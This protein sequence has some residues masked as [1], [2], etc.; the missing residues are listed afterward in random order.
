MLVPFPN[1]PKETIS[2]SAQPLVSSRIILTRYQCISDG[3][4]LN[5]IKL[6]SSQMYISSIFIS[7]LPIMKREHHQTSTAKCNILLFDRTFPIIHAQ[8]SLRSKH[9]LVLTSSSFFDAAWCIWRCSAYAR[10]G[11]ATEEQV[12]RACKILLLFRTCIH[13]IHLLW[14]FN[15]N[16]VYLIFLCFD[17]A[18]AK[19]IGKRGSAKSVLRW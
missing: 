8:K 1:E 3:C 4:F 5:H 6:F 2:L 19:T 18:D 9:V 16:P 12:L 17:L 15:R 10:T 11:S 13:S 14:K 7:D